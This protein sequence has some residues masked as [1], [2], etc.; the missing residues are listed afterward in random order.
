VFD[1]D[2]TSDVVV[3][4]PSELIVLEGSRGSLLWRWKMPESALPSD[5]DPFLPDPPAVGDLNGDDV[6]D[7]V[8]SSCG[9]HVYAIDGAAQGTRYLW[10]FGLTPA[11]KT[12]PSLAD[13]N[14][15]GHPDVAVGD[16]EGNLIFIDGINGHLL[17]QLAIGASISASPVIGDL[18]GDGYID[19]GVGTR[20]HRVIVV[21]TQTPVKK[22]HLVW[23]SF[24]ANEKNSGNLK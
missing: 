8:L 16:S 22:G 23:T 14:A 24:G 11:R 17:S 9:G 18:T 6:P 2:K 1:R 15:D 20:D 7:I 19:V 21:R 12:S 13:L 3:V 5:Q 4:Y 10:D